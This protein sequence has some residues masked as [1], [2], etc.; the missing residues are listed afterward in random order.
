MVTANVREGPLVWIDCEMTGLDHQKDH[1]I[2]ICCLLTNDR[3]EL[4]EE[5]GY[6]AVIHYPKE[7]MDSMNEWCIDHHGK[8]GLTQKVLDSKKTLSEVQQ[9]L[10]DYIRKYS[11]KGTG[12][13]AGNSIHQDRIFLL[14]EFPDV[15]DYLHYRQVDVSTIKEVGKRHNPNLMKSLPRKTNQHTARA[16]ILESIEELKWYTQNYLKGPESSS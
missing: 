8:S 4:V 7:V 12:I 10:L 5:K 13:L 9:E 15:V 2:E 6:E 1:I 16:D 11:I 14:K 3:L